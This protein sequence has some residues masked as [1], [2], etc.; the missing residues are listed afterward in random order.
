MQYTGLQ[1]FSFLVLLVG[2]GLIV[3]SIATNYWS[4]FKYDASKALSKFSWHEGRRGL[5]EQCYAP[6]VKGELGNYFQPN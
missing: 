2:T 6:V 3:V 4:F 1:V 5:Y